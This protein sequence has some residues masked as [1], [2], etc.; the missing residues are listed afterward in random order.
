M[1][2]TLSGGHVWEWQEDDEVCLVCVSESIAKETLMWSCHR[3]KMRE[4]RMMRM[5]NCFCFA[6]RLSGFMSSPHV[7]PRV[8]GH[9]SPQ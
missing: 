1:T 9:D 4:A 2:Y 7:K 3:L 8:N 5:R 6:L